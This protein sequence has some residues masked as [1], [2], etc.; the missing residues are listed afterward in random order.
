MEHHDRGNSIGRQFIEA[1][2][3]LRG[4]PD[5]SLCAVDYTADMNGVHMDLETHRQFT[6][7]LYE[8]FPD[9]QQIVDSVEVAPVA[10]RLQLRL[11]GTHGGA[12]QGIAATG[13]PSRS[14][15]T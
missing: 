2:D 15:P 10:E 5:E 9:L 11:V 4:G 12:F 3:R 14:P 7:Q 6:A 1:Q 8:A 13:K